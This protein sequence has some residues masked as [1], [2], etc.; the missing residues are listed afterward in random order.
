[1]EGC[2]AEGG[3][4]GAKYNKRMGTVSTAVSVE[5]YLRTSFSDGD[6]EYVDGRIIQRNLGERDH[7]RV[8]RKVIGYFAAREQTLATYCFPAQRVQVKPTRFRVPDVCVYIGAEPAEQVFRTPPFLA[9]EILSKDDRAGDVAEKI[10]D[11]LDFGVRFVWIIDP[12][13]RA[14]W[15]HT[16][17]GSRPVEGNALWTQDPNMRLPLDSLF[18]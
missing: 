17:A 3:P 5:E 8:Q 14:G 2:G 1:M 18:D 10:K 9:V 15:V 4:C 7:S 12:A 16:A 13:K 11:Y 6:R